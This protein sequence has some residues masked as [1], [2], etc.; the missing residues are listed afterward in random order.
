MKR[1]QISKT[2]IDILLKNIND[3][4]VLLSPHLKS[5]EHLREKFLN[6]QTRVR[7]LQFLVKKDGYYESSMHRS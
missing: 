1:L 2:E 3:F 5:N 7:L 6:V 4:W